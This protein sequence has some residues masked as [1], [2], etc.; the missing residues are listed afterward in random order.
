MK[1]HATAC[2]SRALSGDFLGTGVEIMNR[3]T[4]I[5]A[6]VAAC[7]ASM[8]PSQAFTDAD[9]DR[10]A[11]EI[12]ESKTAPGVGVLGAYRMLCHNDG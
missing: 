2:K 6:A 9:L 7:A 8:S 12:L 3:M 10:L 5:A 4:W 11:A 1:S